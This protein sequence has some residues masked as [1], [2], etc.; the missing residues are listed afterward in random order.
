MAK[1]QREGFE[2]GT[3]TEL[4]HASIQRWTEIRSF[5]VVH[6][7]WKNG[8]RRLVV[9]VA[10]LLLQDVRLQSANRLNRGVSN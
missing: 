2:L 6:S 1:K 8:N 4:D 5:V 3:R 9:R 10:L 7:L